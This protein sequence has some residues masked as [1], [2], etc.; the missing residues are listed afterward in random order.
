MTIDRQRIAAVAVLT[1]LGWKW[2]DGKWLAPASTP[3]G[4]SQVPTTT[5][6]LPPGMLEML[7]IIR[8]ER[9]KRRPEHVPA[10]WRGYVPVLRH[11]HGASCS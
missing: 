2:T 1:E 5:S 6:P 10:R 8:R 9:E 3:V 4:A 7:E 11:D